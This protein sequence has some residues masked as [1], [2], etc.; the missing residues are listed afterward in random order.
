MIPLSCGHD[1]DEHEIPVV[2]G[3]FLWSEDKEKVFF[4][5]QVTKFPK[6]AEN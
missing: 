2:V 4:L 3:A 1:E 6:Q 5:K